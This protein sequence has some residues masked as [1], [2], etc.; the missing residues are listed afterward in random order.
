METRK[1]KTAVIGGGASGLAAAIV[2]AERFGKGSTVIIERQA[3]TGRKLLATGNG[4]CNI[5]NRNASP[6]H[7]HGDEKIIQSVLGKFSPKDCENFFN[8]IGVLLRDEDEG[9]VYP[10]S[11][12]AS[13]VLDAMR[14][15]CERLGAEEICGFTVTSV[16]KRN[17]MFYICSDEMTIE[18]ENV[19]FA[20]GSQAS[21][22][23]G[24]ND[25]GYRLLH[26]LKIEATPLFPALSP[27]STKEKYKSLK[28]V[29]AKGSV[30]LWAD[31]QKIISRNGEIQFTDYGISGICVFEISRYVN[32]F[33]MLGKIAGVKYKSL[34][35]SVNV[36][37]DYSLREICD[38]LVKCREIFSECRAG[39]ILSG[40]LNKKLSQTLIQ[41]CGLASKPC[42]LLSGQDIKDIAYTAKNFLFTPVICDGY[43][44]SQVSAGGVSSEYVIPET[45]M[46]RNVKN[47][48]VCGELLNVDGDCGGYNL[49]F[50]FGS[51]ILAAKSIP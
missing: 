37:K 42:Y 43:K 50:A 34:Q 12:Q 40:A 48:Y 47:L 4:R 32:E 35:I 18:S 31:D 10:Y 24:A 28:G 14:M 20:T 36:M 17:G 11:N 3:R 13:T 1:V 5:T 26:S 23:L 19:I 39:E 38:Y 21:P 7:Y 33:F 29:R 25:T 8:K 16:T 2:S 45:L 9:R 51:G 22:L 46:A 27:V 6:E 30:T 41:V 49:H 44:S 15:E